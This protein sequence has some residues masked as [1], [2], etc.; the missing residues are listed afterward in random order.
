MIIDMNI[1][2]QIIIIDHI[3]INVRIFVVKNDYSIIIDKTI[4][5]NY[6]VYTDFNNNEYYIDPDK[7]IM[8]YTCEYKYKQSLYF[9]EIKYN[10]RLSYYKEIL[11]KEENEKPSI[12]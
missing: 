9:K 11:E 7:K 2:E 10:P 4:N 1:I 12:S 3:V 8:C 5:F 6:S